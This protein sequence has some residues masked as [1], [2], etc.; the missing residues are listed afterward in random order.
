M[1]RP[2][3]ILNYAYVLKNGVGRYNIYFNFYTKLAECSFL[4]RFRIES[5]NVFVHFLK[6]NLYDYVIRNL[7]CSFKGI[8]AVRIDFLLILR[9]ANIR[10][11]ILIAVAFF[12]NIIRN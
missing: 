3:K 6:V 4:C 7:R 1:I 8:Q 5:V 10:Y 2:K 12:H 11:F 9:V